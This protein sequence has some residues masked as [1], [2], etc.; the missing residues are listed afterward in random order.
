MGGRDTTLTGDRATEDEGELD[1]TLT[2]PMTI[3][4]GVAARSILSTCSWRCR[5]PK[6]VGCW[7]DRLGMDIDAMASD[8]RADES[9][10]GDECSEQRHV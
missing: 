4:L 3:Q 1:P 6:K 9:G 7:P 10:R 8:S 5:V 2:R